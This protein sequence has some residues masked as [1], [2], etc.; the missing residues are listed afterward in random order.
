MG[1]MTRQTGLAGLPLTAPRPRWFSMSFASGRGV[2]HLFWPFCVRGGFGFP[3]VFAFDIGSRLFLRAWRLFLLVVL[4][5]RRFRFV[6]APLRRLVL[7][8]LV[9]IWPE[10]WKFAS[11]NRCARISPRVYRPRTAVGRRSRIRRLEGAKQRPVSYPVASE[12]P[13]YVTRRRILQP[14]AI[15]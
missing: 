6:L 10:S 2:R 3:Y 13:H 15:P 9:D 14:L 11:H 8:A 1:G 4:C 5:V 7:V 12:G